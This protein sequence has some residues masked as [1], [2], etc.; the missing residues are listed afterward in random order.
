MGVE[1]RLY[2]G[3]CLTDL[4]LPRTI[5]LRVGSSV[6]FTSVSK[7]T[8]VEWARS[9]FKGL[10]LPL[11]LSSLPVFWRGLPQRHQSLTPDTEFGFLSLGNCGR[12]NNTQYHLP[13]WPC[14][15]SVYVNVVIAK[16]KLAWLATRRVQSPWRCRMTLHF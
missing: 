5:G 12:C 13:S 9:P 15:M 7:P 14:P 16:V 3:M 11:D 4:L 2:R 1:P 10:Q 6:M 8:R